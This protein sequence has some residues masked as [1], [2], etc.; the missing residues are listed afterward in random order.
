MHVCGREGAEVITE[1]SGYFGH[2]R[3]IE[4]VLLYATAKNFMLAQTN[5]IFVFNPV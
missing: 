1:M 3:S 2:L 4:K 5:E